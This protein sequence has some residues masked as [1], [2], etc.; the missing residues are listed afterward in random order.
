M[1]RIAVFAAL[2]AVSAPALAQESA[3]RDRAGSSTMFFISGKLV[4]EELAEFGKCYASMNRT[5]ALALVA[6][7]AGSKDEATTYKRLF[8]KPY[9]A[10]L[11]NL[12]EVRVSHHIVRGVIAEGLYWKRAS[13]PANLQVSRAPTAQEAKSL[14]DAAICY[15]AGHRDAAQALMVTRL[16]SDREVEAIKALSS[17]FMPCIPPTVSGPLRLDTTLLRLR[18]A[19]ALWRLGATPPEPKL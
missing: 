5:N 8:S 13:V 19:E 4:T 18:I 11:G 17:D 9:Q 15:A 12:S 1:R 3:M 2:V 16:G 6:T 14:S 7:Q 10:C